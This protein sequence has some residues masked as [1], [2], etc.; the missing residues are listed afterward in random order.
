MKAQIRRLITEQN[1]DGNLLQYFSWVGTVPYH[2]EGEQALR[3]LLSSRT[4][5][6]EGA[7]GTYLVVPDSSSYIAKMFDVEVVVPTTPQPRIEITR[8]ELV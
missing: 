4:Y 1:T 2:H 3:D 5:V 8:K 6:G 7:S